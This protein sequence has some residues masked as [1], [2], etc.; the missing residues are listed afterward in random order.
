MLGFFRSMERQRTVKTH[1]NFVSRLTTKNYS[2]DST[3]FHRN[4]PRK[5]LENSGKQNPKGGFK[6]PPSRIV[7]I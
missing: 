5:T 4:S 6:S 7:H 1:G 3:P 2:F